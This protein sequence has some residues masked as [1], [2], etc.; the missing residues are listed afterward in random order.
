MNFFSFKY[1][2]NWRSNIVKAFLHILSHQCLYIMSIWVSDSMSMHP[3]CVWVFNSM[4]KYISVCDNVFCMWMNVCKLLVIYYV[5]LNVSVSPVYCPLYHTVQSDIQ[6]FTFVVFVLIYWINLFI[7]IYAEKTF[8]YF[9]GR[10]CTV[11][12][13]KVVNMLK[14]VTI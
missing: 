6:F 8:V 1:L 11:W 5:F 14:D 9:F 2:N 10:V 3:Y 7:Y 4:N 12:N 13:F